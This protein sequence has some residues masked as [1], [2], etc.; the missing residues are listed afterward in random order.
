MKMGQLPKACLRKTPASWDLKICDI[1]DTFERLS[2]SQRNWE[3]S[4]FECVN[5]VLLLNFHRF[6]LCG[7]G[8]SFIGFGMV[9]D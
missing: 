4:K 5:L 8:S 7:M 6:I 3:L 9:M 2:D 1:L